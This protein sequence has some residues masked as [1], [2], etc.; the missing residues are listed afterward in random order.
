MTKYAPGYT[1][2][3]G[4]TPRSSR[5][6]RIP[7]NKQKLIK[8]LRAKGFAVNKE[9]GST[10]LNKAAEVFEKQGA[11]KGAKM[12]GRWSAKQKNS[13]TS[14]T[15]P[16]SSGQRAYL[17]A[18]AS[19][20]SSSSSPTPT[21]SNGSSNVSEE[22]NTTTT[23]LDLDDIDISQINS[24]KLAALMTKR[25]YAPQFADLKQKEDFI[26]KQGVSDLGQIGGFYDEA[27]ESRQQALGET[28]TNTER[29]QEQLTNSATGLV[30]SFGSGVS[31]IAA[32][33]VSNAQILSSALGKSSSDFFSRQ[34][35]VLGDRRQRDLT[36]TQRMT[37]QELKAIRDDRTQLKAARGVSSKANFQTAENLK[38]G[39]LAA[40]QNLKIGGALA[41]GQ[42]ALQESELETRAQDRKI[43]AE[44]AEDNREANVQ[45]RE[46]VAE[47]ITE[48]TKQ[49]EVLQASLDAHKADMEAQG[50]PVTVE[51]MPPQS[52]AELKTAITDGLYD[53]VTG[54]LSMNPKQTGAT[55]IASMEA[56]G[57]QRG[58]GTQQFIDSVLRTLFPKKAVEYE[59]A[60]EVA[61]R[62]RWFLHSGL[63]DKY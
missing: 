16:V 9:T 7:A 42:I 55:L 30:E 13:N 15:T 8:F 34:E 3:Q 52:L 45:N 60:R 20:P 11:K 33:N 56:L 29:L 35:A 6:G 39:R 26:T 18:A 32:R 51:G 37:G 53:P 1:G 4:Q 41:P 5:R 59:K 58:P 50:Q 54:K 38:L 62:S 36:S 23:D 61:M 49:N 28:Q 40:V 48:A 10:E 46:L 31:D 25:E 44:E 43:R 63:K 22:L 24:T 27:E 21:P 14:E 2:Q 19:S 17:E 12:F 57:F 47:Q